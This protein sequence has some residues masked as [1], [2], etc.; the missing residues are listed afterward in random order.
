MN[1]QQQVIVIFGLDENDQPRA[2]RFDVDCTGAARTAASLM[3]LSIACA[4][5]PL[6]IALVKKLPAGRIFGSGKALTPRVKWVLYD[7]LCRV[8]TPLKLPPRASPK[9]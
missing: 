5:T 2:A 9:R 1:K 3:G 8:L 6:A 4:D 7:R